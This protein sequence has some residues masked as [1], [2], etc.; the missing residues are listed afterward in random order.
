[1]GQLPSVTDVIVGAVLF[2]MLLFPV[3]G[4]YGLVAGAD[5]VQSLSTIAIGVVWYALVLR[6]RYEWLP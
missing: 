2:G 5:I 4:V 3:M 1:M 6:T